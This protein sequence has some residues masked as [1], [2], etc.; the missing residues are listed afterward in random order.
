[1]MDALITGLERNLV[2]FSYVTLKRTL[3]H[4]DDLLTV[5][6]D[7]IT[8]VTVTDD[9]NNND[10]D[11]NNDNDNDNLDGAK[12][13][14]A[15]SWFGSWVD[16]PEGERGGKPREDRRGW[17]NRRSSRLWYYGRSVFLVYGMPFYHSRS[18]AH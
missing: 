2:G 16:Q 14:D 5:C 7:I 9:N 8:R 1:M 17:V 3:D 15:D 13:N 11:D 12:A 18:L 10:N 6:Q 4:G